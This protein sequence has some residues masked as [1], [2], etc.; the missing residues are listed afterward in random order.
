M[1]NSGIIIEIP[2]KEN[3]VLNSYIPVLQ[4]L[5]FRYMLKNLVAHYTND[6]KENSVN[7]N[8]QS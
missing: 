6:D 8:V 5:Y 1:D 7:G 3:I 4:S 2:Y